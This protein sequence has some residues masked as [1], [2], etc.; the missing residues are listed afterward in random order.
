MGKVINLNE[1]RENKKKRIN[2]DKNE[3]I[4]SYD[5]KQNDLE[6]E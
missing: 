1:Y 3:T 5:K 6:F 4:Y 2:K